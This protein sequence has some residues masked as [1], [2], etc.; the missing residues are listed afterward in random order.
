MLARRRGGGGPG[1]GG[2]GGGMVPL[3]LLLLLLPPLLLPLRGTRVHALTASTAVTRPA[4]ATTCCELQKSTARPIM[5]LPSSSAGPRTSRSA[6]S[7]ALALQLMNRCSR[8]LGSE[9]WSSSIRRC[10]SFSQRSYSSSAASGCVAPT[11][12]CCTRSPPSAAALGSATRLRVVMERIL[13]SS[14]RVGQGKGGG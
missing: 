8:V 7:F 4:T 12:R 14:A 2:G 13:S 10:A 1:D 5:G 9:W 3:L 6:G 11:A